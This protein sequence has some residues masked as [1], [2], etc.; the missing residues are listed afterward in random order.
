MRGGSTR[1]E[2]GV[3]KGRRRRGGRLVDLRV[4]YAGV[5]IAACVTGCV[6]QVTAVS[7]VVNMS[8]LQSRTLTTT[9]FNKRK[10]C[11]QDSLALT[12]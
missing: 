10:V 7:F 11:A 1:F 2:M 12:Y 8:Q 6:A 9:Q 3:G 4:E 5:G